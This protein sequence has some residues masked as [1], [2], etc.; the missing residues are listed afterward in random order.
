MYGEA[1]DVLSGVLDT[2]TFGLEMKRV[3]HGQLNCLCG[4]Y[5]IASLVFANNLFDYSPLGTGH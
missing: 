5:Y 3:F 1:L 4:K 2:G